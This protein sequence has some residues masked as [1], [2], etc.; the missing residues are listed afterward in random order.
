MARAPPEV[1]DDDV[2]KSRPVD[3][4]KA[5][6]HRLAARRPAGDR[7]EVINGHHF[8]KNPSWINPRIKPKCMGLGAGRHEFNSGYRFLI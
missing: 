1:D 5:K 4:A 8:R 3:P 7:P 6:R 2:L